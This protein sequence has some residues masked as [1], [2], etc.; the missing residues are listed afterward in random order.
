MLSA[1]AQIQ[2]PH[3]SIATILLIDENALNSQLTEMTLT[4]ARYRVRTTSSPAGG[5]K[6]ILSGGIHAVVAHLS[7]H[8]AITQT[9]EFLTRLRATPATTRLPVIIVTGERQPE[10][11]ASVKAAGASAILKRPYHQQELLDLIKQCLEDTQ[12]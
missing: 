10:V 12:A 2:P 4:G 6:I 5:E 1:S 8:G 9:I 11:L 7:A 3:R